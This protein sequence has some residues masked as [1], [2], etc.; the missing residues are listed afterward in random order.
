MHYYKHLFTRRKRIL[1]L[2]VGLLLFMS[3]TL[4][5]YSYF[6]QTN[7]PRIPTGKTEQEY[8]L[9]AEGYHHQFSFDLAAAAYNE[10]LRI[11][12]YNTIALVGLGNTH[13][14][15]NKLDEAYA[16]LLK[17]QKHDPS[18]SQTYIALGRI[19]YMNS[20]KKQ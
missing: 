14:K 9:L 18:Y 17:A 16:V 2:S 7:E 11:N 19:H 4:L 13:I 12:Q 15:Q 10:A 8:I 6:S 3:G 1:I 20:I 5:S